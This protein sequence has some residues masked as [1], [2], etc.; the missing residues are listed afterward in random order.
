MVHHN[1]EQIRFRQAMMVGTGFA[2]RGIG[3]TVEHRFYWMI[4]SVEA[5]M[6]LRLCT[7]AALV[8]QKNPIHVGLIGYGEV[9]AIF[10]AGLRDGAGA[11]VSA[12]DKKFNDPASGAKAL[13]SCMEASVRA[14]RSMPELVPGTALVISA[15]TASATLPVAEEAAPHIEPGTFYLDVNSASPG[16]KRDCAHVIEAAGGYYVEAVV[17]TSVPPYGI[18]VPMLIGGRH[19]AEA[20]ALLKSLGFEAEIADAQ[21]GV[22]SAVKMCRSVMIKGMEAMVIESLVSAR[23]FGVEQHVLASLAET[24]PGID[25]PKEATFFFSRAVQHGKRRAEEMRESARTVGEAGLDPWMPQA[26][27]NRQDWVAKLAATGAFADCGNNASW[28]TYADRMLAAIAQQA[29]KAA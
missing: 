9:G 4:T 1:V 21:I 27:A 7:G 17:M 13:A 11:A 6:M 20:R 22:A 18:K 5:D 24:F 3:Y 12:Y 10:G 16:T 8:D 29:G 28:Q 15:V 23:K 19:A 2:A 26:T 25:W 14:V